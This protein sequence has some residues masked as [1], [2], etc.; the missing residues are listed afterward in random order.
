MID[1]KKPPI[2][3]RVQ[4]MREYSGVPK[5]TEGLFVG[6]YSDGEG[7]LVAWDLPHRPLPNL[8]PEEIA[9]MKASDPESPLI[10]GFSK[11]EFSELV[12]VIPKNEKWCYGT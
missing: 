2:G 1:L 3:T 11:G 10:D 5:F 9:K 12:L 6:V 4:T 8:P 7:F